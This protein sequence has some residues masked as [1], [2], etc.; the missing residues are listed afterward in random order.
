MIDDNDDHL[1]HEILNQYKEFEYMLN[2]NLT[3]S[4]N[5]CKIQK[6]LTKLIGI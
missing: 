2:D 4:E 1:A 5:Y 6:V 3:N